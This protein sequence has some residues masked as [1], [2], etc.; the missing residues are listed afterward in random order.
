MKE[1]L[2]HIAKDVFEMTGCFDTFFALAKMDENRRVILQDGK[3]NE[4]RNV[5]IT[6]VQRNFFYFRIGDEGSIQYIDNNSTRRLS[7]C[8]L[9]YI[10]QRVPVRL[11][12]VVYRKDPIDLEAE[13]R[14]A[15]LTVQVPGNENAN[16]IRISLKASIVDPL[17]VLSEEATKPKKFDKN[18]FFVAIDFD[19]VSFI[20]SKY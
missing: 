1:I 11:V 13:L 7:S 15:L 18:L 4:F 12:A 9:E 17:K 20:N 3:S 16:G 2:E 19:L 8:S 5:G 10:E 6:D 14:R